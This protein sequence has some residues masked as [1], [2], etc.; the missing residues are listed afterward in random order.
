MLYWIFFIKA[1]HHSCSRLFGLISGALTWLNN[2]K[3][4]GFLPILLESYCKF[5]SFCIYLWF[6]RALIWMNITWYIYESDI[7]SIFVSSLRPCHLR[8]NSS[9]CDLEIN[10]D[11]ILYNLVFGWASIW[12]HEQ[13]KQN[14]FSHMKIET[15]SVT[16]EIGTQQ[17]CSYLLIGLSVHR[18]AAVYETRPSK[19]VQLGKRNTET[20]CGETLNELK[21]TDSVGT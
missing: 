21:Q 18:K 14:L 17:R 19:P 3:L 6:M 2:N 11:L 16:I 8:L 12:K 9:G 7:A 13:E 1:T 4:Y 15:K 20:Q 10:Y 5:Q